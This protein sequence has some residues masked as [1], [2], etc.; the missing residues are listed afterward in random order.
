MKQSNANREA[1]IDF[2]GLMT[3][4]AVLVVFAWVIL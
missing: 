1:L 2:V 4:M 3:F